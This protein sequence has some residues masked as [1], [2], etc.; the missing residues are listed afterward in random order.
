MNTLVRLLWTWCCTY[1]S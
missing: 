1:G